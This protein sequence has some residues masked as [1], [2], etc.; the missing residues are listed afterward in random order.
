MVINMKTMHFRLLLYDYFVWTAQ[1]STI[2]REVFNKFNSL[3]SIY[4]LLNFLNM[5]EDSVL[6]N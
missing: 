3:M 4:A 1:Y 2:L 5:F 6:T